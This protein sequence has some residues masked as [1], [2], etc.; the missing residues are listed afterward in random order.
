MFLYAW[1]GPLYGA[2]SEIVSS[3]E[4]CREMAPGR[5]CQIKITSKELSCRLDS[6]KKPKKPGCYRVAGLGTL[7]LRGHPGPSPFQE[8][9]TLSSSLK[10]EII[11]HASD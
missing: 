3:S 7:H 4:C 11:P 2:D 8:S 10:P 5:A 6:F 9:S 1:R